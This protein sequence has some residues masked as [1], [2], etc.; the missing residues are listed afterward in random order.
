MQYIVLI[1]YKYFNI[2]QKIKCLE[3]QKFLLK[4]V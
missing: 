4:N 2:T 3:N 1:F